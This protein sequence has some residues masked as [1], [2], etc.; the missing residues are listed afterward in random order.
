MQVSS[1]SEKKTV[2]PDL[3]SALWHFFLLTPIQLSESQYEI[4]AA[5]QSINQ[6]LSV[7]IIMT[8]NV[9]VNSITPLLSIM[10]K[11]N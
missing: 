8:V 10:V 7:C 6:A 4:I 2:R 5:T 1:L 3:Y 9:V 11:S